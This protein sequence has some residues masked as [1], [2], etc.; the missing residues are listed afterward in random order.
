MSVQITVPITTAVIEANADCKMSGRY[1]DGALVITIDTQHQNHHQRLGIPKRTPLYWGKAYEYEVQE[2]S[3]LSWPIRY[4]VLAREG[5][6][7]DEEG[8]RV[9]FSTQT[10][11]VDSRR[12]VSEVLMRAAV[13]LLVIAGMGY[14]RVEW[15]LGVLFHVAV[16]KSSLQR[17][18][19]EVAAHLPSG[20]EII[21]RLHRQAPITEGHLDELFPRGLHHCVLVMKDEHGRIL[22]PEAVDKRDEERVKPFLKRFQ[23]LGI[24]FHAFYIDGCKA[25]YNAIRAVFGQATLIQYDSFHIL[26]NA[27]RHL[28]KWAVAHRRR[29][30][31]RAQ[32]VTTPWYKRKLEAL[33]KDLWKHRFLLFKAEKRLTPAERQTLY[34]LLE[35]DPKVGRLRDFLG[36]IWRI[37]EDSQDESQA[38]EALEALKRQPLDPHCSK[39]FEKVLNFLEEHF[40][41]MTTFLRHQHVQRNSLAETGMRVLRR[42]EIE[43][44]GFRSE[45]GREDFLRIYQAIRYLGW[46]IYDPPDLSPRSAPG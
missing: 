2:L 21:E 11:G 39:P 29:L 18:V 3:A 4:R 15:L 38:Q 24:S 5:Y 1:E 42:L 23:R 40:A 41:W 33:A 28:R 26:Q 25:Y 45:K 12:G 46:S 37:F 34:G 6:Y 16:S 10:S 32:A 14:R 30:K 7:L 20:D 17:W 44:D 9:Y 8:K 22:A 43:H 13:V 35:A 27:W 19:R 31:K 36:G